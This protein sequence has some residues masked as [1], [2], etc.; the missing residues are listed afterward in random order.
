MFLRFYVKDY[1][2]TNKVLFDTKKFNQN[3]TDKN[4]SKVK[5]FLQITKQVTKFK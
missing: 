3:K 1:I 5:H 4:Y 2:I